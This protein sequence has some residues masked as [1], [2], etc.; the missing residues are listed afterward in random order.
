MGHLKADSRTKVVA[1]TADVM[2]TK[3]VRPPAIPAV[4]SGRVNAHR[5]GRPLARARG[6]EPQRMSTMMKMSLTLETANLGPPPVVGLKGVHRVA[7]LVPN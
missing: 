4:T 1:T 3:N 7:N 2:Y 5:L 6:L